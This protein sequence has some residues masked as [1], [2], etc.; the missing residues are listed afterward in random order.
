MEGLEQ[1]I[2]RRIEEFSR[3][4]ATPGQGC[5]RLPFS[6][7]TRAAAEYLKEAMGQLGL[8]VWEDQAG[9]VFGRLA[10]RDRSLPCVMCGSHLDSV[11]SGG[12][13]DGAG[14]IMCALEMARR[15]DREKLE[16]DFVVCAL[17]DE[18]GCRFGGGYFGSL[19]VMGKIDAAY[20]RRVKDPEG[21][22][23]AQQMKAYG[24]DPEDIAQ[25]AWAPG[26]IGDYLEIHAEQGPVLDQQGVPL[27]L[28]TGIVG[29]RRYEV[30]VLGQSNHAGT[31]PM[32]QRK[33]ALT[34]AT[35]VFLQVE[36][37]A[38]ARG[39]CVAT[40]GRIQAFPGSYN[41]IP[42]RAEFLLEMRA[43]EQER[44]EELEGALNQALEE[45][46]AAGLE[47]RLEPT[48]ASEPVRLSPTLLRYNR[49]ACTRLGI[50]CLELASGAGHDAQIIAGGARAAMLFVPSRGGL[51]HCPQ[52]WSDSAHLAQAVQVGLEL[53]GQ[54]Q[55]EK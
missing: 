44:L 46:R 14:G 35:R 55:Q 5:T 30:T 48:S 47:V 13:Y 42:G 53:V 9:S 19:S 24:L 10:G 18:E 40:V 34:G 41:I 27:G 1:A 54:L 43:L 2:A 8:E 38:Q 50:P 6:K 17:M 52:E 22:S 51:S 39:D 15:L 20:C 12:N 28:V 29:I 36:E 32:D 7:E 37:L 49:E 16:R 11:V 23:V 21:V 31:T 45:A 25:A 33:D 3:F 26:S 4:T